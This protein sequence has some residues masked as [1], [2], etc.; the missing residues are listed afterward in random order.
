MGWDRGE[1]TWAEAEVRRGGRIE[2]EL[3]WFQ[4]SWEELK[5][6]EQSW[7]E[8]WRVG[9]ILKAVEKSCK[10]WEE[11]AL[12]EQSC[13]AVGGGTSAPF[14]GNQKHALFKMRNFR[15]AACPEF[16]KKNILDISS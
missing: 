14:F 11:L 4:K 1:M 6:G 15:Q 13:G 3:T 8:G 2:K 9:T 12:R 5:R 16:L 7:A 10:N